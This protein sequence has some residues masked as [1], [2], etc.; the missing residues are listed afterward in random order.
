MC[1]TTV[2][3]LSSALASLPETE[4]QLS[5]FSALNSRL[6][7]ILENDELVVHRILANLS[8]LNFSNIPGVLLFLLNFLLIALQI[9]YSLC[10]VM[11]YLGSYLFGR[12]HFDNILR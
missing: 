6:K 11:K 7:E 3:W 5:A 4:F 8:L 10:T 2:A 9:I 12:L 1:L